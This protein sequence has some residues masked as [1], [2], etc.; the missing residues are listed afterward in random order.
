MRGNVSEQGN[1]DISDSIRGYMQ[2]TWTDRVFVREEFDRGFLMYIL[3]LSA[4]DHMWQATETHGEDLGNVQS[5]SDPEGSRTP[6]V[7]VYT[8]DRIDQMSDALATVLDRVFYQSARHGH[9]RLRILGR[10]HCLGDVRGRDQIDLESIEWRSG[11]TRN[12]V[13]AGRL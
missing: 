2:L 9:R 13:T 4:D 5:V 6:A 10:L 8:R 3:F 1:D 7:P 11:S 12:Y